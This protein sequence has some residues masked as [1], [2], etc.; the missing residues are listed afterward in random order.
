[1]V[2]AQGMD[3][4][5]EILLEGT[6]ADHWYYR[7]KELALDSMLRGVPFHNVLDIGAGSGIFSRHLL[8]WGA[9]SAVCVDSAYNADHCE[10]VGGKAIR[11][12]RKITSCDADLVLLMDVL[13]HVDDDV[14]L[15]KASLAGAARG[16]FVLITVP[17]FQSLYSAHDRYLDHK[18][19]YTLHSLEAAV[20]AAGLKIV[21]TRY[22]FA[23]VLPV[24]AAIRLFQRNSAPKSSLTQHWPIVNALLTLA[25]RIELPL[26]RYNRA[27]GLSIFCLA[28]NS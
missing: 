25:H 19:R 23:L 8:A 17:A 1:M 18:R 11:F 5:E 10:S 12:T 13:E 2:G 28:R 9:D 14:Q 26:F 20:T 21:S 6:A 24:V 7:A 22:F 15:I 4:K 16:A 27:G 3:I